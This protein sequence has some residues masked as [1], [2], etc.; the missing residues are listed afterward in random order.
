MAVE[1]DNEHQGLDFFSTDRI[2][3]YKAGCRFFFFNLKDQE[4]RKRLRV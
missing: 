2:N 1:D 4:V 3:L